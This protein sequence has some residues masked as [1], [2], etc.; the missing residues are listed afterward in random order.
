MDRRRPVTGKTKFF[1]NFPQ[2]WGRTAGLQSSLD[3]IQ[4]ASLALVRSVIVSIRIHIKS[5]GCQDPAGAGIKRALFRG[6]DQFEQAG[7]SFG[8]LGPPQ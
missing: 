3:K 5:V 4:H 1:R 2:R 6:G 7:K 8:Q